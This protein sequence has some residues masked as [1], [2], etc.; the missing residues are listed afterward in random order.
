M[1]DQDIPGRGRSATDV[2]RAGG[3]RQALSRSACLDLLSPGGRGRVA[4][5]MRAI[6]VVIP[7]TFTL[8]GGDVVFVPRLGEGRSKAVEN[9][10]VA[11]ET[12]QVETDG[13]TMWDVHVTGVARIIAGDAQSPRFVLSSDMMAGWKSEVET[14]PVT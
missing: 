11:F 10:V 2:I 9:S 1:N 6:P 3:P 8:V 5:T 12:D 14:P 13:Q 7:V 4:A